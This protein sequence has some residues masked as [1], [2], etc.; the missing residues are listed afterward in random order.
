M[1]LYMCERVSVC[2]FLFDLCEFPNGW[3]HGSTKREKLLQF[4]C[5][6]EDKIDN[7]NRH[8]LHYIFP[9]RFGIANDV[10]SNNKQMFEY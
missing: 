3:R 9:L 6:A 2:L 4:R 8:K 5:E 1:Y 7:E 10:D